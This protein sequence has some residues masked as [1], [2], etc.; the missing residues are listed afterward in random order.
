MGVLSWLKSA[1]GRISP[2]LGKVKGG[3]EGFGKIYDKVKNGYGS[4]KTFLHKLQVVG[5]V[6]SH[7]VERGENALNDYAKKKT[8]IDVKDTLGK[9]DSAVGTARKVAGYLPNG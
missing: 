7:L 1:W 3:I 4:F 8:G 5:G 6:A 9:V 2:V